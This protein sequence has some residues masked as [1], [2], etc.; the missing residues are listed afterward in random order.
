VCGTAKEKEKM[1]QKKKS[2][3]GGSVCGTSTA[4]MV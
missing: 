2:V 3:M 4:L 1:V